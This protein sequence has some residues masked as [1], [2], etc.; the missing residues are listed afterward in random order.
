MPNIKFKADAARWPRSIDDMRA[1][2]S[3]LVTLTDLARL[4]IVRS[5]NGAN[6]LP[7][8]VKRPSTPKCWEARAIL[9]AMGLTEAVEKAA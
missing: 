5:Y 8:P 7:A 1:E 4:G 3:R 9:H 6:W 2:P